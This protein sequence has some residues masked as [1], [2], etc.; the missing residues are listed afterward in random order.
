MKVYGNIKRVDRQTLVLT[1][2]SQL[3]DFVTGF[4]GLIVPLII[5][6]TQ[7]DKILDM[8]ETGKAILNFQITMIL[9][10]VL[11]IPLILFAL[12]GLVLLGLVILLSLVFPI[13]NAIKA[14]N[15]EA[16]YYPL[17]IKFIS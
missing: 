5:W 14:N 1:H 8:D 6:I 16:P 7:R 13:V 17:S 11:S 2:L 3:L 10:G 4:G 15:G 9:L 12:L